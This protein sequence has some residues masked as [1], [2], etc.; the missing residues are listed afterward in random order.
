MKTF[1][2]LAIAIL[3][4][5]LFGTNS[6][7]NAQDIVWSSGNVT[8]TQV[9]V[10]Y[11]EPYVCS[12]TF[13]NQRGASL[14]LLA[15][16]TNPPRTEAK[17]VF[18]KVG[19]GGLRPPRGSDYVRLGVLFEGVDT[20]LAVS[21]KPLDFGNGNR[22]FVASMSADFLNRVA[23]AKSVSFYLNR[24]T[25]IEQFETLE[26]REGLRKLGECSSQGSLSTALASV[27]AEPRGDTPHTVSEIDNGAYEL[28]MKTAKATMDMRGC[29]DMDSARLNRMAYNL[30]KGRAGNE[31]REHDA[32]VETQNKECARRAREKNPEGTLAI[33]E[34]GICGRDHVRDAVLQL[35]AITGMT[36]TYPVVEPARIVGFYPYIVESRACDT[37]FGL[38]LSSDGSMGDADRWGSWRVD[39]QNNLLVTIRERLDDDTGLTRPV[40]NPSEESW[41]QILAAENG[42]LVLGRT[43]N[44]ISLRK[45]IN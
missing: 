23:Q 28:C 1:S 7:A 22:G 37:D 32:W 45:C 2:K 31:R 35:G 12:L 42:Y 20:A 41:G 43:A 34:M 40:A 38:Q 27:G 6:I 30:L 3:A 24:S 17:F 5:A 36:P 18:N 16:N 14:S 4:V 25:K 19:F 44:P 39:E 21:V 9:S 8:A 33:V 15:S 11:R 26:V 29:S 10:T 13:T